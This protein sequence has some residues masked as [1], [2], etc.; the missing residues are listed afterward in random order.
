MGREIV[1]E[2][3]RSETPGAAMTLDYLIDVAY[4]AGLVWGVFYVTHLVVRPGFS[5]EFGT[6]LTSL[7]LATAAR[8]WPS[9]FAA[10]FDNVLGAKHITWR[11]FGRSCVMSL[12]GLLLISVTYFA[13]TGE[14]R[15]FEF[16]E[17]DPART[18]FVTVLVIATL[19]LVPDYLSLLETRLVIRLLQARPRV[20][21]LLVLLP[22]DLLLTAAIFLVLVPPNV[23]LFQTLFSLASGELWHMLPQ[24]AH[25][26]SQLVSVLPD[27]ATTLLSS[28]PVSKPPSSGL[29]FTFY[30][31]FLTSAWVWAFSSALL[32]YKIA[33]GFGGRSW[34]WLTRTFLD[35]KQKPLLSL[36]WIA[37]ALVVLVGLVGPPLA[38]YF[39]HFASILS[40]LVAN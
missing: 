2:V 15:W 17:D 33:E 26:W 9:Y 37:G 30:T 18:P 16:P 34:R 29:Y 8:T 36:G 7:D 14:W 21:L 35:M 22:L 4:I 5:D 24:V 38:G 11:C 6:Q 1:T 10:L 31:T 20:S 39:S 13:F 27:L 3:P 28:S 19:N 12:T 32:A 23:I 25:N 40:G